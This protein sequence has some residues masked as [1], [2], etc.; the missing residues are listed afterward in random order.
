MK[1]V[2]TATLWSISIAISIAIFATVPFARPVQNALKARF[3]E[4]IYIVFTLFFV[5]AGI[6]I[7]RRYILKAPN[8][9]LRRLIVFVFIVAVY[10][11]KLKQLHIAVERFHLIEYGLLAIFVTFAAGRHV[12][13]FTAYGWGILST[14]LIGM[15][16]EFFQWL[17]PDRYG[18]WRDVVINLEG[19]VLA[20]FSMILMGAASHLHKKPRNRSMVL[21]LCGS[22]IIALLSGLF[23]ITVQHFGH[24][25]Q[26]PDIGSFRSKFEIPELLAV[27]ESLHA[28]TPYGI[29]QKEMDWYLREGKEHFDRTRF[30]FQRGRLDSSLREY[31]IS[32]RFYSGALKYRELEFSDEMVERLGEI[33]LDPNTVFTSRIMD[34]LVVDKTRKDV[35]FLS[36]VTALLCIIAAFILHYRFFNL[37]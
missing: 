30:N 25:H 20:L 17:W 36:S 21:L 18:E 10:T 35:I 31:L 33:P 19:G 15:G 12:K 4:S 3:G 14:L 2:G 32:I 7:F 22:T 29:T 9:R 26:V 24:E 1:K 34:W 8:Q 23:F 27:S 13:D 5:A 16:D 28:G 11:Y 37:P 6:E